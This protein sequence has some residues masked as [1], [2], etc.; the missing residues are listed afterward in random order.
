M[1]ISIKT[2]HPYVLLQIQRGAPPGV[3][4]SVPPVIGRRSVGAPEILEAIVHVAVDV[5]VALLAAW[6]YEKV[7]PGKKRAQVHI[8]RIEV[9]CEEGEIKKVITEQIQYERGD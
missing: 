5:D 4:V 8:N 9:L 3:H 2:D 6:L 7:R 1:Q